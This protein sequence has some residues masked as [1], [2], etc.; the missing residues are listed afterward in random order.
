MLGLC[1]R[2]FIYEFLTSHKKT[3]L[4]GNNNKL[5]LELWKTETETVSQSHTLRFVPFLSLHFLAFI[6]SPE[7]RQSFVTFFP[8]HANP[9]LVEVPWKSQPERNVLDSKPLFWISNNN[10][11]EFSSHPKSVRHQ[12]VLETTYSSLGGRTS[13]SGLVAT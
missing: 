11:I 2:L 10:F 6:I 3:H 9:H 5:P 13:E 7:A 1:A 4:E 8:P 12:R